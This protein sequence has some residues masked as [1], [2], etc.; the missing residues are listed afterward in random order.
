MGWL[1]AVSK[2]GMGDFPDMVLGMGEIDN[3]HRDL[4]SSLEIE[5]GDLLY[6][7]H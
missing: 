7:F 1:S 6:F 4:H 2:D 3:L 5:E